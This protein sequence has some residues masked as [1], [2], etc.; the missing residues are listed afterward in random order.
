MRTYERTYPWITFKHDLGR[1]PHETWL[2]LGQAVAKCTHIATAPARPDF[3]AR[4]YE[5]YLAR[6]AQATTAIE[7]NSL[8]EKQVE[9][10]LRD[11]IRLPPSQQYLQQQI[12]NVRAAFTF[13][14]N[15]I[16]EGQP[17]PYQIALLNTYNRLLLAALPLEAEVTP[18]D[19][20]Q[21]NV[22]VGRYL[23]APPEDCAFL[24]DTLCGWLNEPP[25]NSTLTMAYAILKALFAHLY[26]AWIHPYGD[27]N[28]R[29]ARLVEFDL[30]LRAGVPDVSA[31]LLSNH[32]NLTRDEYYRHLDHSHRAHPDNEGAV[33]AFIRYAL[34]GFVDGMNAQIEELHAHQRDIHWRDFVHRQ[35]DNRATAADGRRRHLI[36]DLSQ[37]DT[38]D[39]GVPIAALRR[40][41]PRL[42]ADYA[43]KTDKTLRRDLTTL[44]K[45]HL[46][47]ITGKTVRANLDQLT[48]FL[49]RRRGG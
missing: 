8:T 10:I 4:F 32:Y 19:L 46:L 5:V 39:A 37:Q 33:F 29:T 7:G 40:L 31:H 27:G 14:G 48:G 13:V 47:T 17:P 25:P 36:L 21:H 23:G 45:M 12:E 30:L 43:D 42:A 35:F 49:P 28:G 22:T 6:G 16:L 3:A 26:I 34:Q 18:G 9:A 44:A 20:R 1:L 41:T 2:L 38:A 15:S 11:K 24:L